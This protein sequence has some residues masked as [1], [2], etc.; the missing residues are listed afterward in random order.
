MSAASTFLVSGK[1]SLKLLPN[2][3][4]STQLLIF[5]ELQSQ[6]VIKNNPHPPFFTLVLYIILLF[7]LSQGIN[8]KKLPYHWN[9]YTFR[10]S[11][12][13][14][15]QGHIIL[16]QGSTICLFHSV[17]NRFQGIKQRNLFLKPPFLPLFHNRTMF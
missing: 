5:I 11:I 1:F 2:K 3:C 4:A 8:G 16:L 10:F 7:S 17:N 14:F 12:T 9:I 13:Y 15:D 6:F